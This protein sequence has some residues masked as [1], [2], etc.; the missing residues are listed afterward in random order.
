[1]DPA[2]RRVGVVDWPP[3]SEAARD[4]LDLAGILDSGRYSRDELMSLAAHVDAG[5]SPSI[6][7]D[8]SRV[9]TVS[10]TP[11]SRGMR[12]E[13]SGSRRSDGRCASR[14]R[15]VH[16]L[17]LETDSLRRGRPTIAACQWAVA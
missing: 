13:R 16:L 8:A 5:F 7:S 12:W 9:S 10:L 11:S 3:T 6:F 1:M 2:S 17:R 15:S 4:Y 14:L